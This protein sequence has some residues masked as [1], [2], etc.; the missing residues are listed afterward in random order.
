MILMM[1]KTIGG[2]WDPLI[3]V[4]AAIVV[5]II[6]YIIRAA[7]RRNHK[8]GEQAKPFFSGVAEPSKEAMHVR[9]SNL[10]WGFTEALK[11]YYTSMKKMH[12]GMLNDYIGWFVGIAALIFVVLFVMEVL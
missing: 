6:A 11:G 2:F 7:G 9:A 4:L 8:T 5:A 1:L 3:L 12:S 10:Y